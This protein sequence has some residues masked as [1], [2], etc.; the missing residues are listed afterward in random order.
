MR[1]ARTL[2]II[3]KPR[4]Y[5]TSIAYL[6]VLGIFATCLSEPLPVNETGFSVK[7]MSIDLVYLNGGKLAGLQKGDQLTIERSD[8]VIAKLEIRYASNTSSSC[9]ILESNGQIYPNDIAFLTNRA[10]TENV[11]PDSIPGADTTSAKTAIPVSGPPT[12]NKR[13]RSPTRISGTVS[14]QLYSWSDGS[15]ENLDFTQT[16]FRV[17][18]RMRQIGGSGMSFTLR[19]RGEYDNRTRSYSPTTPAND[20]SNRIHE[21]SLGYDNPE[22]SYG[23]QVGRILPRHLSGAG[24]IDGGLLERRLATT[25]RLGVIAGMRPRWQYQEQAVSL[26]KYGAYFSI[27]NLQGSRSSYEQTL[28]ISGEYHGSTVSREL[29]YLQ[30]QVNA[31]SKWSASHIIEI[32]INRGWRKEKLGKSLS[33]SNLYLNS[34]YRF[35]RNF[36]VSIS[37]DDRRNYWTYELRSVAD[38]LFDDQLRR[39]L[40]GQAN[41]HLPGEINMS[42]GTGYRKRSDDPDPTISYSFNLNK[43]GLGISGSSMNLRYSGFNGP[44][45]DGSN[46]GVRFSQYI[47]GSNSVEMGY[48]EYR[49]VAGNGLGSRI[50]HSWDAL[51]YLNLVRHVFFIGSGQIDRG[52]DTRGTALRG[53]IGYRF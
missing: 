45:S 17:N 38:S 22:E 40:R 5:F 16:T 33:L 27:A 37:Y 23:F 30:G 14:A 29:V 12:E 28:A 41:M 7:Y 4:I 52:D 39:G 44:E 18:M 51:L 10:A 20:W 53:E 15:P 31:G 50:N 11:T 24:Y 42:V 2:Q 36:N 8:S 46:Y 26:Q 43:T 1:G 32:D 25:T 35:H 13:Q 6:L 47:H 34:R 21:F 49:Y 19:T 3:S 9:I 48:S